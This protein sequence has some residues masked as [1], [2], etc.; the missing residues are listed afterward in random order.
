[1][2]DY[3]A[4][5]EIEDIRSC[6]PLSNGEF[7]N[8]VRDFPGME[9][10]EEWKIKVI[11]LAQAQPLL[12]LLNVRYL[13]TWPDVVTRENL[14]FQIADRSDF[15]VVE[16]PEAWP[17]AFFENQIVSVDS[18]EKFIKKLSENGRQPFIALTGEEIKKQHGI[19][20]LE[21]TNH[22]AIS[23]A[24]DY[25][26]SVN[27]TEFDVHAP[28]AGVVCLTEGQAKDFTA[29]A[30]NESKPILTVNRA[31]KGIYL[32]KPGDYH[33]K[34]T[35]RPRHW[36]L[37]CTFFLISISAVLALATADFIRRRRTGR[38]RTT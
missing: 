14:D 35:Y 31:F 25:H 12:N 24:T 38:I 33:V 20:Q 26:L 23:P 6:A 4:V 29:T 9:L 7:I 8:L 11:N 17:R 34:F 22:A 13:L 1:M 2:G 15:G 37:S 10:S 30:N 21:T 28:T 32:D 19:Q 27:S 3:S 16:N 36:R 5:Y 18:N